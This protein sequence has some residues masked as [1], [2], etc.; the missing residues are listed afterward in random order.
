MRRLG[1]LI[2]Q[3]PVRSRL[4]TA[5][6]GGQPAFGPVEDLLADLWVVLV[7]ANSKK[8]SLPDTFDH[9]ARAALA[10]RRALSRVQDLKDRY[11]R[12]KQARMR[13]RSA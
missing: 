6:N 10:A 11:E 2:R 3:L 4:V 1:V 13:G 7:R 9:P 5:L 12:R 8:G